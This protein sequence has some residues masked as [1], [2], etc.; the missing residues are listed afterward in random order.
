M[1]VAWLLLE[2]TV[3]LFY[4][5]WSV[6]EASSYKEEEGSTPRNAISS[7]EGKGMVEDSQINSCINVAD[8]DMAVLS[9]GRAVSKDS[10]WKLQDVSLPLRKLT[11]SSTAVKAK[12]N[13]AKGL[14]EVFNY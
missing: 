7:S 9:S 2:V 14:L 11:L 1:A 10:T 8:E 13:L 5:D 3:I 6:V 12:W 4:H